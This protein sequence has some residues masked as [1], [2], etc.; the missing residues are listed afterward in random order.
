MRRT[1]PKGSTPAIITVGELIGELCRWPDHATVTFRCPLQKQEMRFYRVEGRSPEK[2]EI[3][4]DLA[5]E[6]APV[7][8]V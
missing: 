6:T 1:I 2:V 4:L 8:P 7:V 5:P 3:E